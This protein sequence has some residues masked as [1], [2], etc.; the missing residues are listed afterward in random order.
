MDE[1]E[2]KLEMKIY[3]IELF[4]ANL[5]AKDLII[6]AEDPVLFLHEMQ[7]QMIQGV[8]SLDFSQYDQSESDL[9]SGELE[10]AVDRIWGMVSEQTNQVLRHR[11]G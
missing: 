7:N 3:A 4:I 9:I 11:R 2:T 1:K 8:K 10:A 6:S 5:M